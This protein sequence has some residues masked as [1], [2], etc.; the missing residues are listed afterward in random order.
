MA[1][2]TNPE[3]Y[4]PEWLDALTD[5]EKQD[6]AKSDFT[7]GMLDSGCEHVLPLAW[8]TRRRVRLAPDEWRQGSLFFLDC[9]RG[10]FAVTAGHVMS[11]FM[12]DRATRRVLSCQFGNLPFNPEERLIAW[13]RDINVDIATFRV[14]LEEIQATGKQVV[15]GTNGTWPTPAEK[16]AVFFGGFPGCERH[17]VAHREFEFG[18]HSG[19]NPLTDFTDYQVRCRFNRKYW[20]DTRGTGVPPIGYDLGGVSGGPLLRP[21]YRDRI[22]GWQLVGVISEA[23]MEE[24]FEVITAVRAHFIMPD[25]QLRR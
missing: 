17:L 1:Q 16:Q 3:P 9:G 20:V 11:A 8:S 10:P 18:L 12:E 4:T 24:S 2:T 21:V 22:W 15:P 14:T 13:G 7:L 6:V 23:I 19:I 5:E 25:G